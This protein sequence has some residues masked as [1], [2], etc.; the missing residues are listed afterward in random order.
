MD[1]V[2]LPQLGA[3]MADAEIVEWHVQPGDEVSPGVPLV[4]SEATKAVET[5]DSAY[6]GTVLRLFARVGDTVDIGGALVAIGE[7]GEEDAAAQLAG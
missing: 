1:L 6:A 2:R 4:D 5:L 3:G 7:P